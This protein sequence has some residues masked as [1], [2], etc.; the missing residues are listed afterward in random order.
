MER[1]SIDEREEAQVQ[2]LEE[3]LQSNEKLQ[4]NQGW[5]VSLVEDSNDAI[6][7]HWFT[8]LVHGT[9]L[10]L[11]A[12]TVDVYPYDMQFDDGDLISY[13][14]AELVHLVCE[15]FRRYESISVRWK[16]LGVPR[17]NT[18]L[19]QDRWLSSDNVLEKDLF[20]Q[21]TI[22]LVMINGCCITGRC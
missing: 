12:N 7:A 5:R 1:I 3:W 19:V 2:G 10:P 9:A 14:P 6:K 18:A 11:S 13:E 22:V 20:Y 16:W 17:T 8:P 15:Q 4:E 21:A